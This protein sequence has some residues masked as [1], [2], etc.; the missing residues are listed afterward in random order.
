MDVKSLFT[1]VPVEESIQK[2]ADQLYEKDC[3]PELEKDTFIELMRL[4]AKKVCFMSGGDWYIQKDGV[5]MGSVLAYW[6]SHTQHDR[7]RRS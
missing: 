5:A 6:W 4:T 2:A 3:H 1:N 7:Y